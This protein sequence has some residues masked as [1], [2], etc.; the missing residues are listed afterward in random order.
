MTRKTLRLS[1]VA[2]TLMAQSE[3][4]MEPHPAL[5]LVPTI[6]QAITTLLTTHEPEFLRFGFGLFTGLATI[7]LAWEGIRLMFSGEALNE[8]MFEF[9][10]TLL[11]VSFG[12][13][14][15]TFYESPLPG[16]GVSFSNLITDQTFYFQS[17]LEARAFD[18][19]Y[20]HLDDSSAHFMQQRPRRFI[21]RDQ[22][23]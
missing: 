1:D 3:N 11:F 8:K 19:L 2:A 13:A 21:Q 4:R 15:I 12:Y 18:N 22:E 7:V 20:Q 9:A 17:V 14:L 23:R 16:I 10:K 6:Q 5:N